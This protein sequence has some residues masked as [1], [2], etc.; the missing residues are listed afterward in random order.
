[1]LQVFKAI[2]NINLLDM[3]TL[4]MY[5]THFPGIDYGTA[6]PKLSSIQCVFCF[7]FKPRIDVNTDNGF[8]VPYLRYYELQYCWPRQP[9]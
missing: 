7:A 1:M 3:V 2:S 9:A 5:D 6:I 4:L 8:R